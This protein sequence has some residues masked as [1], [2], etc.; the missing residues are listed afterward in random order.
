MSNDN[1]FS[2]AQSKTLKYRPA[3]PER[4]G[5]TQHTGAP[6]RSMEYPAIRLAHED[7]IA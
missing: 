6:A 3:F 1:P 7:T 4:F 5:P 2:E